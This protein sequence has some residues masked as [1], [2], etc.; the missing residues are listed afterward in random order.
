MGKPR[1]ELWDFEETIYR[2]RPNDAG[3]YFLV[4]YGRNNQVIRAPETGTWRAREP[5]DEPIAPG[6]A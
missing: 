1:E 3:Y 4:R 2:H 5:F 6:G